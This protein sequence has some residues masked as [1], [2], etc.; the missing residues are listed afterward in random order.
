MLFINFFYLLLDL[1]GFY[2]F[3]YFY[4]EYV[5]ITQAFILGAERFGVINF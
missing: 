5:F 2:L 1:F 4:F 3:I